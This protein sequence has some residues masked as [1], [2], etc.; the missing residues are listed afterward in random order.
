MKKLPQADRL[1]DALQ[2]DL[3]GLVPGL[4]GAL[5][6]RDGD[7]LA[8]AHREMGQAAGRR[9]WGWRMASMAAAAAV[10]ASAVGVWQF[11]RQPDARVVLTTVIIPSNRV[12]QSR[13]TIV[14]AL[15]AAR[16]PRPKQAE[17][18]QIAIAAVSVG[19][20]WE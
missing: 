16:Q 2:A 12:S 13:P 17:I 1:S 6:H 9:F 19:S 3:H 14:A 8:Y 7:V 20:S 18:D 5:S 4:P 15:H 11:E 10:V